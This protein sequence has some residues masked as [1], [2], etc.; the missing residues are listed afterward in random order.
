[1]KVI[2]R[3]MLISG[4]VLLGGR[5]MGPER[6]VVVA[7]ASQSTAAQNPCAAPAN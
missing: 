6:P 2:V 3:T 7:Q 5:L 1:M 4:F